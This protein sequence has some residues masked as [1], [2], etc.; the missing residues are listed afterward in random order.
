MVV[1]RPRWPRGRSGNQAI[2]REQD[3]SDRV[4][5]LEQLIEGLSHSKRGTGN[6]SSSGGENTIPSSGRSPKSPSERAQTTEDLFHLQ[7]VSGMPLIVVT[8]L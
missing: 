7:P 4:A 5:K 6:G 1:E 3:L 2:S 8:I